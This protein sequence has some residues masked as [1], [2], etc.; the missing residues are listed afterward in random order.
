MSFLIIPSDS[1]VALIEFKDKQYEKALKL[2][3]EQYEQG[4][5]RLDVVMHLTGVYLQFGEIDK[6]IKVMEDYVAAHPE[7]LAARRELGS[8]YQYGQRL[9]DYTRNLEEINRLEQSTENLKALS[10]MYE[11]TEDYDKQV[12]VVVKLIES[13]EAQGTHNMTSAARMLA[14]EKKYDE[15]IG[16]LR[17]KRESLPEEEKRNFDDSYDDVELLIRLLI[18]V[19]KPEEALAE[20]RQYRDMS[21]P[22]GQVANLAN[23]INYLIG[24]DEAYAFIQPYEAR[25][26]EH[27]SLLAEYVLILMRLGEN[28]KAYTLLKPLFEAQTLPM[29]L[30]DELLFLAIEQGDNE[31]ADALIGM[32]DFASLTEETSISLIELALVHDVPRLIEIINTESRE[33]GDL[34]ESKPMLDAALAI[35]LRQDGVKEK[36]DALPY[37]T[38]AF[39]Q[40]AQLAR[41]CAQVSHDACIDRFEA[42]LPAVTELSEADTIGTGE[43][44]L[45]SGRYGSG[46]DYIAP[47][48]DTYKSAKFQEL[49]V[50][51]AAA[52]G[53]I[54]TVTAWLD[55]HPN[56]ANRLLLTDLYFHT[57][58][59]GHYALAVNLAERIIAMENNPDTR[60]YLVQA[61]MKNNQLAEAVSILRDHRAESA[62]DADNYLYALIQLVKRDSSYADELSTYAQS[63]LA[64]GNT[65]Y[66]QRL[67]LIYALIDAG[68]GDLAMPYVRSIALKEGGTWVPLYAEYVLKQG[69]PDEAVTFWHE[70]AQRPHVN[71]EMLSQ[72]AYGL[73]EHGHGDAAI[74]L[75][76][77]M[78]LSEPADSTIVQQMVYLWGPNLTLDQMLWLHARAEAAQD[79]VEKSQWMSYAVNGS[80]ARSLMQMVRMEPTSLEYRV[81]EEPYLA[82][83]NLT[84]HTEYL[85]SY[86]AHRIEYTEN[87]AELKRYATYA[88]WYNMNAQAVRG[89][90]KILAQQPENGEALLYL[91]IQAHG[92]ANY[93]QSRDM[94]SQ[95]IHLLETGKVK[96]TPESYQAYFYVAETLRRDRE[97]EAMVPLYYSTI[98]LIQNQAVPENEARSKLAQALAHS[99]DYRAARAEFERLLQHYPDDG[100]L[101]ADYAS[102]LLEMKDYDAA[103]KVMANYAGP[104][105]E[106]AD[107][108]PLVIRNQ[109]VQ[110]YELIG[111]D[112]QLVV[113]LDPAVKSRGWLTDEQI[114]D[115]PWLSY[116]GQGYNRATLVAHP[117][118][119][120]EVYLAADGS[121]I[122]TPIPVISEQE[123]MAGEQLNRRYVLLDARMKL[124]TGEGYAAREALH[125]LLANNP[126][127]PEVLGFTANAENYLRNW[128]RALK[129][130]KKAQAMQPDNQDIAK[131]M[132]DINRLHAPNVF[133]DQEWRMLGDNDEFITTVGGNYMVDYKWE[134][135]VLL[136]HNEMDTTTIRRSNGEQGEFELDKQR[137]EVYMAHHWEDG[138]K[139]KGSLFAN[140]DTL[141]GGLYFNWLN[142]IGY[143]GLAA[144]YHRPYWNFIESV[145]DDVTRDR[146]EVNHA[147]TLTGDIT[148]SA[149][150]GLNNYNLDVRDDVFQSG[151]FGAQ[152]AVPVVREPYYLAVG[153]GIDA[154]YKI[155]EDFLTDS[156]GVQFQSLPTRS[157]EIHFLSLIGSYNFTEDT[158]GNATVGYA[159]DRLGE[160]G[161]SGEVRLTHYLTESTS[162]EGRASYGL[163]S[164]DTNDDV[165]RLGVQLK[166]RH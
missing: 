86:L 58:N 54:D 123:I 94:L 136:Q 95:Y 14:S 12:P 89:Y 164:A 158:I 45:A 160:H 134:M 130:L 145:A 56:S 48:K 5:L 27:P 118:Y 151:F 88:T 152:I 63:Q 83:V 72:I 81:V 149:Q 87:P 146:L 2:Y 64:S 126:E 9:D 80:N 115:Y 109:A 19:G 13:K 165:T 97:K 52:N 100:L 59:S 55:A 125:E 107:L 124:E 147:I 20:A 3:E 40:R 75:F 106:R 78:A 166:Y 53:D 154:E 23:I 144:E 28:E 24:V 159:I 137:A 42:S 161:P 51:Y 37:E 105:F 92:R 129:L 112:Q 34:A 163:S 61:Y 7:N 1:E 157:R 47:V 65:S 98:Q 153:Y 39:Y 79:P 68:Q 99:G 31:T 76:E 91:G 117:A 140:N 33:S 133:L 104:V 60:G 62:Q 156:N 155:D 127:N 85:E 132:R 49:W 141:G 116:T 16:M 162:V 22:L 128:P 84:D 35:A 142:P 113:V 38:L 74:D 25:I 32:I 43:I 139:L 108:Q 21:P 114:K 11:L 36:L 73:L 101:R 15:A 102:L 82:A 6:A 96:E 18:D 30:Q 8:L 131:L 90:E 44:L 46:R 50:R 121:L 69:N 138:E 148:I 4:N 110:T 120:M 122:V 66:K 93:T 71:N 103:Q 10:D 29:D 70:L 67:A 57:F 111:Y 150:A 41:V 143:T 26:T 77:Q 135:G 17:K 119:R